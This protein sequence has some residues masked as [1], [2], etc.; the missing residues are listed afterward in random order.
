MFPEKC[1]ICNKSTGALKNLTEKLFD[2]CNNVMRKRK[3]HKLKFSEVNLT[4]DKFRDGNNFKYHTECYRLYKSLPGKENYSVPEDFDPY[5]NEDANLEEKQP[6][7]HD[8]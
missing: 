2:T 3:F 6:F 5:A 4:G 1:F 7:A 8:K